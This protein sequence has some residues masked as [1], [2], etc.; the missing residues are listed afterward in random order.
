MRFG[1]LAPPA[2]AAWTCLFAARVRPEALGRAAAGD[3]KKAWAAYARYRAARPELPV[4]PHPLADWP[5]PPTPADLVA[6]VLD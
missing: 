1:G 2:V 5:C 3:V 6:A 4:S